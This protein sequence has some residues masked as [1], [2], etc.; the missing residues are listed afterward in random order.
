MYPQLG[1]LPR[2]DG[3]GLSIADL[4][5]LVQGAHQNIGR[6]HR[7]L[8]HVERTKALLYVVDITGFQLSSRHPI[9]DPYTTIEVLVKELELYHPG[10][11]CNRKAILALNKMDMPCALEHFQLL[12]QQLK[13]KSFIEF[14]SIIGCSALEMMGIETIKNVLLSMNR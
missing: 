7:F 4:P 9:L 8:R 2:S 6:G 5:G 1:I 10:L 11:A 14:H 12:L 3:G 13:N